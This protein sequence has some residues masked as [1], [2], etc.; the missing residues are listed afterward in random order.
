MVRKLKGKTVQ[1]RRVK[2]K[3]R[4]NVRILLMDELKKLDNVLFTLEEKKVLKTRF[5]NGA[6]RSEVANS[7]LIPMV[8]ETE[9]G[10]VIHC[11]V[12]KVEEAYNYKNQFGNPIYRRNKHTPKNGLSRSL[13][14]CFDRWMKMDDLDKDVYRRKGY[15]S[16]RT[17]FDVF[18]NE[19]MKRRGENEK[20]ME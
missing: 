3:G 13:P 14:T 15:E 7:M 4:R 20:K 16:G 12:G 1:Q 8:I 18:K 17:G 6:E 5:M 19:C 9:N 2:V 11:L 10:G